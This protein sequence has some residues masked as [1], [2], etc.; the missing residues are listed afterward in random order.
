MAE[1]DVT[2]TGVEGRG[3]S[4]GEGKP[5]DGTSGAPAPAPPRAYARRAE[6]TRVEE[7][8]RASKA[9]LELRRAIAVAANEAEVMED[10]MTT[11]LERICE[12]T[13][14]QVGHIYLTT[15]DGKLMSTG[16]WHFADR[17]HRA[18]QESL[19]FG[20]FNPRRSP[21]GKVLATRR[22]LWLSDSTDAEAFAAADSARDHG[23]TGWAGFP[24]VAGSECV[25]VME[26]YAV[27]PAAQDHHLTDMMTDVGT[28]LG[29]VMERRRAEDER[30]EILIREQFL[31]A[32]FRSL[33]QSTEEGICGLDL[34]GRVS[35]VNRAGAELLGYTP[36]E[37][38]GMNLHEASHHTRADGTPYPHTD[39]PILRAA[40]TGAGVRV[41][42]EVFWHSDG[43]PFSVEYSS[44]AIVDTGGDIKGIV[45]T[46]TDIT[47]RR[48][49]EQAV[50]T[51]NEALMN[52]KEELERA[53]L[54][55]SDFLAT[56]SHELR[57]PSTR[58]WGLPG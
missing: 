29:R 34:D 23:L 47:E 30:T 56:M 36:E 12:H 46:F 9:E 19:R 40:R 16:M 53:N 5:A 18:I 27:L 41:D 33:L 2:L 32:W 42:A 54:L 52:T 37:M 10:A 55:K 50:R 8:K 58:S 11:A 1:P 6:D 49:E 15:T 38:Q 35:F 57:T 21:P 39:C 25:G 13:G 24:I 31:T 17:G 4:T 43:T 3:G 26:F 7:L 44:H 14:W 51:L 45:L 28:Q 22:A 20:T 48:R